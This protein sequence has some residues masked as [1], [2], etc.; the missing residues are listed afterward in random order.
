M[1]VWSS[2]EA[3][4]GAAWRLDVSLGDD[5][6]VLASY[7]PPG[8]PI[9]G[10]GL[11]LNQALREGSIHKHARGGAGAENLCRVPHGERANGRRRG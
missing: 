5:A 10:I 1:R 4:D 9:V 2:M 8:A 11:P 6:A 7:Q 3:A